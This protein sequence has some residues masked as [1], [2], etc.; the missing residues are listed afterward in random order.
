MARDKPTIANGSINRRTNRGLLIF[1]PWQILQANAG[2]KAL[3]SATPGDTKSQIGTDLR[4]AVRSVWSRIQAPRCDPQMA[5]AN[6]F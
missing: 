5:A 4:S 6:A 3:S 2:H 1:E